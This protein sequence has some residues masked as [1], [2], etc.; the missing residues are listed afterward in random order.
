MRI[1][2]KQCG[3][4]WTKVAQNRYGEAIIMRYKDEK[5]ENRA[6]VGCARKIDDVHAEFWEDKTTLL[7]ASLKVQEFEPLV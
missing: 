6:R 3:S 2:E 1:E 7:C 5:Y 4:R